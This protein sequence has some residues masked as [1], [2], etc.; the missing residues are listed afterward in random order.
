MQFGNNNF[1]SSF[2]EILNLLITSLNKENY[3][4]EL[5]HGVQTYCKIHDVFVNVLNLKIGEN[6]ALFQDCRLTG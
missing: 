4:F 3:L 5:P 2:Y 1:I 6:D